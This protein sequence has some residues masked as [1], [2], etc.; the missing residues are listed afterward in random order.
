MTVKEGVVRAYQHH[1]NSVVGIVQVSCDTDFVARNAEFLK[2][3]DDLAMQVAAECP[4][5]YE[6]FLEAPLLVDEGL[7]VSDYIDEQNR[8]FGE[9][10][11]LVRFDKWEKTWDPQEDEEPVLDDE[12][13][14]VEN[15]EKNNS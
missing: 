1:N 3:V 10:I 2:F 12:L 4:D 7:T 15:D 5:M 8:K 9:T 14:V 6:E 11:V 13:D